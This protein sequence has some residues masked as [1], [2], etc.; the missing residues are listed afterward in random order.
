MSSRTPGTDPKLAERMLLVGIPHC[1]ELGV[2]VVEID[3]V[4][5]T[6][7]LAY[8]ER[9]V[10]NPETGVLNGGVITTL[11]DSVCGIAVQMALGKLAQ[12]ATLDLRIDYLRGSTPKEPLFA[13]AN[14]YKL[15]RQIAF[16]RGIAHNGD[17]EDPVANCVATFMITSLD[18]AGPPLGSEPAKAGDA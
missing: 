12:I 7:R 9:L 5:C 16:V 11:V 6:I 17:V 15:T 8:Q 14:C 18:R 1:K 10:G 4:R 3:K 2:E 13:S